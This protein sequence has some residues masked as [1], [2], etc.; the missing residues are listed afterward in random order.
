MK[1]IVLLPLLAISA[2]NPGTL[3]PDDSDTPEGDTDTD[4]DTDGDTDFDPPEWCEEAPIEE[5][6]HVTT[7]P[8]QPY[9]L[10]HPDTDSLQIPTV[11]F[12]PGGGGGDGGGEMTFNGWFSHGDDLPEMRVVVVTAAD[13]DLT[14]EWDRVVPIVDEVLDCY[15]GDPDKVHIGGTSNG[16]VG[17][18]SIFLDSPD[19]FATLLGAPGLWTYWNEDAIEDALADK[20]VFNGVG[21]FDTSWLPYVQQ[22]HEQLVDLDIDS[23]YVEFE[24][25]GHVPDENF[26]ESVLYD[27]WEEHS[28]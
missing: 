17:A 19:R 22:T 27:W 18:F 12:L 10:W 7:P 14:D 2:C 21:E 4:T 11:V 3:S 16:G 1:P 6:Q 25:Q 26:D 13:E 8:T 24:G 28:Q 20:S 15:G 5:L 23:V 9:W